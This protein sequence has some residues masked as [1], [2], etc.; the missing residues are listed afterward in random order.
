MVASVRPT[1]AI[2][3]LGGVNLF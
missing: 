3:L 1:F 2:V